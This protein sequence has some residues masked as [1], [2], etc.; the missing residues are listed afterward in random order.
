MC[1]AAAADNDND[2]SVDDMTSA[3]IMLIVI[4][5]MTMMPIIIVK[6]EMMITVTLLIMMMMM[7]MMLVLLT[8]TK[9]I[10]S[11]AKVLLVFGKCLKQESIEMPAFHQ[12]PRK[13]SSQEKMHQN[14]HRLAQYLEKQHNTIPNSLLYY[15]GT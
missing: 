5:I 10:I 9:N 1:S 2:E 4:L 8:I 15:K 14:A 13:Q 11:L 12:G 6:M 3:M 7:I